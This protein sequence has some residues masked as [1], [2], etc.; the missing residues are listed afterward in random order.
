MQTTLISRIYI[1]IADA[2]SFFTQNFNQI[3][4]ICL[5][6]IFATSLFSVLFSSLGEENPAAFMAPMVLNLLVYPIYIAALIHLM[7]LRARGERPRSTDLIMA[8]VQQ[9]APLLI[10]KVITVFLVAFG[11]SFALVAEVWIGFRLALALPGV[12]IAVRLVF[13]EFYLVLFGMDARGA[14]VKS[15]QS[16]RRHFGLLLLLMLITYVPVLI[17]GLTTDQLVQD[18]TS[19]DLFRVLLTSAWSFIGLIVHVVLFR[20]FMQVISEQSA[21]AAP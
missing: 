4:A 1:I 14:I 18:L 11:F 20:A 13:A 10:L 19:Q 17:L 6:F 2:V 16:T 12:W 21:N 7:A 5:P 8:A 15:F 9:W 3:A